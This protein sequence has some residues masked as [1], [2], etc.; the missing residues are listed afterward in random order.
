MAT[1]FVDLRPLDSDEV[2][3][4]ELFAFGLFTFPNGL[5]MNERPGTPPSDE[6]L[7]RTQRFSDDLEAAQREGKLL[8]KP[9][10]YFGV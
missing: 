2:A 6:I 10:D 4:I 1:E 5:P 9:Q 7:N 8:P 3:S